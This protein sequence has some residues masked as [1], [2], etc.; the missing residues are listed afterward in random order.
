MYYE[1]RN[2]S[3]FIYLPYDQN[4][5]SDLLKKLGNPDVFER[6]FNFPSEQRVNVVMPTFEI[7]TPLNLKELSIKVKEIHNIIKYLEIHKNISHPD[8]L[9]RLIRNSD[10]IFF[11]QISERFLN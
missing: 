1:G 8:V 10:Y 11:C 4:G 7:T 3:M 5:I 2:M 9:V 6:S